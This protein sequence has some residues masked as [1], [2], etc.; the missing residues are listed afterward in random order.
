MQRWLYAA[1]GNVSGFRFVGAARFNRLLARPQHADCAASAD[2]LGKI[3]RRVG[4]ERVVAGD[5]GKLGG[6]YI[7]YLRVVTAEGK[8][9][10]AVSG[11]LEPEKGLRA[12][13]RGLAYQLLAPDRYAGKLKVDVAVR[14]A[15][16]YLDGRRVGRS[17]MAPLVVGVGTH[18]LRV[19]H[20][21]HHDYVRFVRVEFEDTTELTARLVPVP[22]QSTRMK[23]AAPVRVLRD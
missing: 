2:C 3:A 22:V 23:L 6:G 4:V 13:A 8:Q 9:L 19:T 15:W 7:V 17:P 5:V 18:A 14:D 1:L 11:V 10:R 20:S 21:A 12:V 16:I